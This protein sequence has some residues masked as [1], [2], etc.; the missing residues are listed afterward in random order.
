MP[1][2]RLRTDYILQPAAGYDPWRK[3]R[4]ELALQAGQAN[5]AGRQAQTEAQQI[6]N[7]LNQRQLERAPVMDEIQG[8]KLYNDTRHLATPETWDAYRDVWTRAGLDPAAIPA[9][10]D[11]AFMSESDNEMKELE[12]KILREDISAAAKIQRADV[13]SQAKIGRLEK[14]SKAKLKNQARFEQ[15][16]IDRLNKQ[17]G[18]KAKNEKLDRAYKFISKM[19]T[20]TGADEFSQMLASA[21]AGKPIDMGTQQ[22]G[23][24]IVPD[25]LKPIYDAYLKIL[26]EEAG[27]PAVKSKVQRMTFTR[28]DGLR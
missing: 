25:E 15:A 27:I 12:A 11:P 21:I 3:P 2:N 5:I 20:Q 8:L 1:Q 7:R 19:A 28:A 16:K 13:E 10:F 6:Q 9:Q 17:K 22:R 26:E 18:D 14:E 4:N 23:R 24:E